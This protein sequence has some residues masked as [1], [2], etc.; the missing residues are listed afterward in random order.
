MRV[1]HRAARGRRRSAGFSVIEVMVAAAILLIVALGL[2][3]LFSRS[4]MSNRAGA[5]AS[6][7]S[8]YGIAGVESRY[9]L[10]FN[11]AAMTPGTTSEYFSR[12]DQS[13]HA[14]DTA[15]SGDLAL[16]TRTTAVS[17]YSLSDLDDDGRFNNPLPASTDPTFVHIK[18]IVVTVAS[19]RDPKNMIG[20]RRPL[21]LRTLKPF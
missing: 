1:S 7:A 16:W 11:S 8:N 12:A 19:P 2:I 9:R 17:Q 3:P 4:I 18:E 6:I 20:V 13:W 14:G 10:G 5:D 21:T 15:P